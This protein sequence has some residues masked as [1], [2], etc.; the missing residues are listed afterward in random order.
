MG[1]G[2]AVSNAALLSVLLASGQS[3]VF[4]DKGGKGPSNPAIPNVNLGLAAVPKVGVGV[5]VPTS[6]PQRFRQ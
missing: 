1:K 3:M 4:A 6:G 5:V 2:K